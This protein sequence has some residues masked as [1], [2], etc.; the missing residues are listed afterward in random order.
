MKKSKSLGNKWVRQLQAR[1]EEWYKEKARV[2]LWRERDGILPDPYIV[3]VSETMLQQTQTQRVQEKLPVFLEQFPNIT[4]LAAATNAEIITAWEGMGYNSRALRLRDCAKKVIEQHSGKIPPSIEDL[5][6]LPGIGPYTASAIAAFAYHADV[7]VVDVN[8]RRVYSRL[9]QQMPTTADTLPENE[10]AEFAD[11]VFPRKRASAWHQAVMDIGALYCTSRAPKCSVC[12][13]QDLCASANSMTESIRLKKAEPSFDGVPNR[14]WRGRIVQI[15]RKTPDNEWIN[16]EHIYNQLFST[17]L[18]LIPERE[19][20]FLRIL[21]GLQRDTIVEIEQ[22]SSK[23]LSHAETN[24]LRS[25]IKK[26]NS[27]IISENIAIS[28]VFI[29]LAS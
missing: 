26:R 27:A 18:F 9:L 4:T 3:L 23:R 13:V 25:E 10:V 21:Q 12:P 24:T 16:S 5:R 20:W 14:I 11:H 29:R 15:L 22:R 19:Q 8:I 17:S 2:F 28:D 6:A 1:I 7:A